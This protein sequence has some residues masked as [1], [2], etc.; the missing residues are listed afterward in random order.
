M[1]SAG[2]SP[3]MVSVYGAPHNSSAK[4][5]ETSVLPDFFALGELRSRRYVL[6]EPALAPT[7]TVERKPVATFVWRALHRIAP[8]HTNTSRGA[9][10]SYRA[11]AVPQAGRLVRGL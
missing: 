8:S 2:Y 11:R 6:G 9:S 1:Y 3:P 7:D 10:P 5:P 4:W